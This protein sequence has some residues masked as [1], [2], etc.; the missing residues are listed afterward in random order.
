MRELT[1]ANE[2][3]TSFEIGLF[4]WNKTYTIVK[5]NINEW[6]SSGG[7]LEYFDAFS[8]TNKQTRWQLKYWY[9]DEENLILSNRQ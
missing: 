6:I 2:S 3:K 4:V 8:W 1:F 7:S 5:H 9:V